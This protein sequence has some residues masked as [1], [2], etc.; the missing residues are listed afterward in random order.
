MDLARAA[1][2]STQQIRNYIAASILPPAERAATG[3]RLLHEGHRHA[4]VAYRTLAAGHGWE[5]ARAVLQSVHAGDEQ[6]ALEL[7]DAVHAEI[8][9]QRC[10]LDEMG[11]ALEAVAGQ[12]T[13]EPAVPQAGLRIGEVAARLG[14]RTSAL[15]VWESA[16]L[17]EPQRERGT[18]YRVYTAADVRDARMTLMLRQS[19]Y[20]LTQIRPILDGLR[21]SG[22][23]A[24]LRE[25]IARR[26]TQLAQRSVAMLEGASRLHTY[27]TYRREGVDND[28]LADVS[29]NKQP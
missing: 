15:R 17:L 3:Y 27:L 8:H 26:K 16:G 25:A 20:P 6:R 13:P 4:L 19:R 14:V 10:A 12:E 7:V 21:T 24:A 2:V 29:A 23:S 22:S 5:N 9:Q 11:T 18:T 28:V 1:G